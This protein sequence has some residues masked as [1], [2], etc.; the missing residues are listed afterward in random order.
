M[1][2]SLVFPLAFSDM[3]L[4]LVSFFPAGHRKCKRHAS[5]TLT[6]PVVMGR[7]TAAQESTG[8]L[9]ILC[10]EKSSGDSL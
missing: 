3:N 7:N 5:L 8:Q 1:E 10:I 9:A 4:Y 6:A 2:K